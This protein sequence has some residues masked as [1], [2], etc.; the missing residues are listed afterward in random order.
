LAKKKFSLNCR[1]GRPK[2]ISGVEDDPSLA[3]VA[4]LVLAGT[5]FDEEVSKI[6]FASK[7]KRFFKIFLP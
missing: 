6:G 3:V 4:G 1:L 7:I 2:G 5:D